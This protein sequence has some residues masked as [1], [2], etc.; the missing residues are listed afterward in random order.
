MRHAVIA[1]TLLFLGACKAPAPPAEHA[2]RQQQDVAAVHAFVE[3]IGKTFNTGNLD[4]FMEVFTEDAIQFN[5]GM[6]DVV[7]RP[8]IR[9]L[10]AD[11]LAQNDIQ[12]AFHTQEV[13][14]SGELAYEAGTYDII[15]RPRGDAQSAPITVTN[16]HVHVLKRQADGA[17]KTWR[18]MTNNTI[19]AEAPK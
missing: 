17:W 19:A 8:A 10:Y 5:Q 9:R 6:P 15:I 3:H 12:V 2:A 4:A 18:M 14:V 16:R 13:A 7:G 1:F 11:A